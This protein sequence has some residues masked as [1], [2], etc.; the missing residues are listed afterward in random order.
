MIGVII[1][2]I[3]LS[4][5]WGYLLFCDALC[6]FDYFVSIIGGLGLGFLSTILF[7]LI[8]VCIIDLADPEVYSAEEIATYDISAIKDNYISQYYGEDGPC[9][10]FLYLTDN[11]LKTETI[12]ADNATIVYTEEDPYIVVNNLRFVNP[13]LNF[14]C[15]PWSTEYTIYIPEGSVIQDTYRI[16]LE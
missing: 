2:F 6:I 11:G 7:T 8:A 9:Y 5:I 10:S 13:I 14:L 12:D 16:D 3:I 1:I 15:G 4:I